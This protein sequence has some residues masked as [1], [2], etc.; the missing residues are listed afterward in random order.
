MMK[1]KNVCLIVLAVAGLCS[2]SSSKKATIADMKGEWDIVS[3]NGEA[4]KAGVAEQPFIGF[5]TEEGRIYG[6]SGCNRILGQL[7]MTA[8]PGEISFAQMGSTRM[9]C[10]NMDLENNVLQTLSGV[11]GYK[12]TG[13]DSF[14]FYNADK[15]AVGYA[16]GIVVPPVPNDDVQV[17]GGDGC[18]QVVGGCDGLAVYDM[19]GIQLANENLTRG[20]YIAVVE[21]D[22]I[23]SVHKVL[24]K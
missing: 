16:T 14:T 13:N 21:K 20:L 11:T 22:G 15:K 9:A 4:V 17:C 7:D 10:P 2:C 1:L 19:S 6:K 24:V 8:A 5:D 3:L 12:K 18:V 23:K